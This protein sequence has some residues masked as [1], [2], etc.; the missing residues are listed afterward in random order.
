MAAGGLFCRQLMM[1]GAAPICNG[2][3]DAGHARMDH[4]GAARGAAQVAGG[5]STWACVS[6]Y[7]GLRVDVLSHFQ[8]GDVANR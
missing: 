8:T 5:F 7:P 2:R 1:V 3:L 6:A 4:P